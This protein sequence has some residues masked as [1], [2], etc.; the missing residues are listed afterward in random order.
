[1]YK[2]NF[3]ED[4]TNFDYV[5]K[6]LKSNPQFNNKCHQVALRQ[7]QSIQTKSIGNFAYLVQE[8]YTELTKEFKGE[9]VFLVLAK[10]GEFPILIGRT[11][12]QTDSFHI[13]ALTDCILWEI[14]FDYLKQILLDEDPRNFILLNYVMKV[15][16]NSYFQLSMSK[17]SSQ[18]RVYYMLRFIGD[19]LGVKNRDNEIEM[20]PFLTYEKLGEFA[21]VSLSHVSNLMKELQQKN[22]I[23]I[24]KRNWVLKDPE[25]I[26][27]PVEFQFN[28]WV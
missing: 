15:G 5:M 19:K 25:A 18:E 21:S 28:L 13:I 23:V 9:Q 26:P 1:M 22:I 8:G 16:I 10:R 24:R 17:L 11:D 6:L 12:W 3:I 4:F 27:I 7:G 2:K 14:E 20:P